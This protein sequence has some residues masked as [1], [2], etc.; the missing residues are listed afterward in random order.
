[1]VVDGREERAYDEVD[2]PV[3]SPD[4]RR[5]AYRVVQYRR[6]FGI[7][8]IEVGWWYRGKWRFVVNGVESRPYDALPTG[9]KLVFHGSS[10]LQTTAIQGREVLRVEVEILEPRGRVGP[11]TKL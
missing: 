3:F 1:V 4:S 9:S 2:A 8:G 7:R 6:R 10:R 5:L 11:G